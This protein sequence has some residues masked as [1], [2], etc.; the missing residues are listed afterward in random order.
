M[1][2]V[3]VVEVDQV[4]TSLAVGSVRPWTVSRPYIF[5]A[6]ILEALLPISWLL[7]TFTQIFLGPKMAPNIV[8]SMLINNYL[9]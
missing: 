9:I 1:F 6:N 7:V 4:D 3:N 5:V 8:S 2:S